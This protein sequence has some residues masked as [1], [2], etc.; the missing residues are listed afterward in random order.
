MVHT[1][2]LQASCLQP[3]E[4]PRLGPAGT[5]P[6]LPLCTE[7]LPWFKILRTEPSRENAQGLTQSCLFSRNKQ[8]IF[9][10]LKE[11]IKRSESQR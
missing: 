5:A 6:S 11:A 2:H 1:Q 3:P 9:F 10:F 4:N 7:R 8:H